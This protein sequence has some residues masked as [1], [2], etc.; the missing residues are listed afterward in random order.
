VSGH[1]STLYCPGDMDGSIQ[2]R[3][4]FKENAWEKKPKAPRDFRG[5]IVKV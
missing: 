3:S 2:L 1:A 4:F 5:H